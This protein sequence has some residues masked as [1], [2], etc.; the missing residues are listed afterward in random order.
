MENIVLTEH[1][2]KIVSKWYFSPLLGTDL[3]IG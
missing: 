1:G 2:K 3:T